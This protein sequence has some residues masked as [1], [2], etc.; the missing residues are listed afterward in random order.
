MY[1]CMVI[2]DV[3][4]NKKTSKEMTYGGQILQKH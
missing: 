3:S 4:R 2:I 1:I